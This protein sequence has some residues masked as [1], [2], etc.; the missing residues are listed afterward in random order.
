MAPSFCERTVG[1]TAAVSGDVQIQYPT[2]QGME[3]C[4]YSRKRLMH[5]AA[6]GKQSGGL[7]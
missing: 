2:E 1:P 6:C 3:M 5:F 4:R 7:R